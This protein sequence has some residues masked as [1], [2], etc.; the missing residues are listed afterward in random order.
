[1]VAEPM[2]PPTLPSLQNGDLLTR[3]EF[4]ARWECQPGLKRAE[5]IEGRV[6]I[7][8]SVSRDHGYLHSLMMS[9]LGFFWAG[10]RRFELLDNTTFRLDR[11]N[12]PQ[13]DAALRYTDPNRSRTRVVDNVIE[14]PPELVV[15]VAVSSA[16][17]DLTLKKAIYARNSVSEY[18]VWNMHENR[19]DWWALENG[20]YVLLEADGEGVTASRVFPGLRL[21]V[22]AMLAGDLAAVFAATAAR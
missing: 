14:G 16:A 1:M 12:D 4:E 7:D 22:A 13:P 15:E 10:N 18:I 21:D 8:V 17:R 11:D 9:W 19:I 2:S 5:L 6:Y 20:D 3:A